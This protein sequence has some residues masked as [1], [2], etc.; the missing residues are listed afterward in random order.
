MTP[1]ATYHDRSFIVPRG[2]TVASAWIQ[3]H[4]IR[5]AHHG[6]IAIGDVERAFQ[7]VLHRGP[8]NGGWPP[9]VGYWDGG[10][11]VLCDGRHEFIASLM[12][13]QCELFVAWVVPAADRGGAD[14]G[15]SQS[16]HT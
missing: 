15:S 8:E 5:F 13:G 6:A 2:A 9:P 14:S 7:R 4:I 11:F 3:H 1:E 12:H 10:T 16:S